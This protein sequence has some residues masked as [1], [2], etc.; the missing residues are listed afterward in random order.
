MSDSSE[1]TAGANQFE[2][3]QGVEMPRATVWPIVVALGITMLGAG[4]ATN[5]AAIRSWGGPVC[6][7]LAG[8]VGQLLPG[9]GHLHEPL[10]GEA[11]S[12]QTDYRRARHGGPAS[13][14]DGGIS[15]ST[16]GVVPSHFGRGRK[17]E[18]WGAL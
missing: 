7:G 13:T 17:V 2:S 5:L 12:S 15:I 11:A 1:H 9:R 10:V 3:S 8:W 16:S 14:R 6:S 4:W 18:S